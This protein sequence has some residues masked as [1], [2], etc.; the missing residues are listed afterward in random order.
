M[1]FE[2]AFEVPA[3]RREVY[4]FLTQP[5]ELVTILPD[6]QES[7][8][9]DHSNFE[10]RAKVGISY[11]RGSVALRFQI[12]EKKPQAFAKLVGRGSGIQSTI[13]LTL[14]IG[15]QESASGGTSATW[16]ADANVGGL[17]ASV[18]NRLLST[19]AEK[20]INQVTEAL[21]KKFSP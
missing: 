15:L 3:S 8:V 10:V 11:I 6:V 5:K 4:D 12:A 21:K 19:V 20:Y 16:T 2:G 7:K 17:L 13:D 1:H 18:G 14:G 9:V